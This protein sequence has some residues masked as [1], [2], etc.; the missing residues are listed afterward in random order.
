MVRNSVS[1]NWLRHIEKGQAIERVSTPHTVLSLL[2]SKNGTEL[3]HHSLTKDAVWALVPE[4][5]WDELE[6]VFLLTG[7]L[8]YKSGQSAGILHPGDFLSS[9]PVRDYVVFTALEEST[10]LYICSDYV[11]H[12]YSEITRKFM[13]L[14]IDIEVKDGY[15]AS[16]CERIRDIS[17]RTGERLEL[18]STEL[19][20]LRHGAFFHDIG[21]I[22]IPNEILTKPSKLS[23]EEFDI[24]KTHTVLGKAILS[25]TDIPHLVGASVVAEQH[26]ERF[27]GSGYPHGLKGDEIDIRAAIVA[28][29]DSFDA[30][31]SNRP[32][33]AAKSRE[34]AISEI[35]ILRGKLYHPDVVDAFL[36]VVYEDS[37]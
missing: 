1:G 35:T 23:P 27:D 25:S 16:H 15:T 32:Y 2:A 19:F 21:K 37:L 12:N 24:I 5:D 29:V 34:Q 14:A 33:Q 31:T 6:C 36:N 22:N 4:D 9:E 20:M 8:S 28:V 7:K 26:H 10:F 17:Y 11:F 3:I 30:M 13:K 18:S